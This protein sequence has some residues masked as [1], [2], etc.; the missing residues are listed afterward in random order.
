MAGALSLSSALGVFVRAM[1]RTDTRRVRTISRDRYRAV[2]R[3][4]GV[5]AR[6]RPAAP[7]LNA[8]ILVAALVFVL[9]ASPLL[10]GA[11]GQ[12]VS[13][14]GASL[15]D[16]FPQQQ[17]TRTLELPNG[18]GTVTA[19]DPVAEGLPDFTKDPALTLKGAVPVFALQEG[20]T[21][22]IALNGTAAATVTPDSSGAFGTALTLRDG[23][24]A[25]ALTLLAGKD[26][27]A[28]SSYTVV[29]DRTPPTVEITK[30][31]AGDSVDG[32]NVTVSGKA[33]AGATVTVNDTTVVPS[34]DGTFSTFVTAGAGPFTV[35][36]LARDRA[37]NE[38]TTKAAITVRGGATAGPLAVSV[39]LDKTKVTPG[40]FVTATIFLTAN[41]APQAN[42]QVTLSVGVIAI[43][44]ATTDATGVARISF[45]APPNEGD[46]AVVVIAAGA[47]GR[48]T[49]TVA[50]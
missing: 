38:T 13:Q 1:R 24:N 26:I 16:V 17:G 34:Q 6:L 46:A 47:S 5:K 35:T 3:R 8:V 7:V 45:A 15:G 4:T 21:V 39:T 20:R 36:V 12:G 23:P 14:L 27:V 40:A 31:K 48:A 49:L 9:S 11:I 43:A 42:Q 30:P 18:G 50:K 33:E 29:L 22:E 44:S 41:G 28:H 25:I 32:P 37:G 2:A 10:A 19:A